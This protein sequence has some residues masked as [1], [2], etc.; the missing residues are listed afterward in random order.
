MNN[1]YLGS[2]SRYAAWAGITL[3]CAKKRLKRG[4][5][6]FSDKYPHLVDFIRSNAVAKK[7]GRPRKSTAKRKI[8]VSWWMDAA[9][10]AELAPLHKKHIERRKN[11]QN[12]P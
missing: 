4:Q 5:I 12:F 6:V 1:D 8:H 3:D 10:Y 7:R 9:E 2:L 11:R